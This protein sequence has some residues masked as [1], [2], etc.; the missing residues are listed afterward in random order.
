MGFREFLKDEMDYQGLT[1]RE[2]AEKSGVSKRTIDHYLMSNPQ[3]PSV[4]NAYKIAQALGVSI[5]YLL[6]G[7]EYKSLFPVTGELLTFMEKYNALQNEHRNLI[8]QLTETLH[9]LTATR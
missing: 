9:K 7:Q 3:E 8:T 5:E 1:T 2:L 4:T 6:T